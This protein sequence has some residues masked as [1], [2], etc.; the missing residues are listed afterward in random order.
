MV[1]EEQEIGMGKKNHELIPSARRLISSLR[2][3]GYDFPSAVADIVDNSIEAGAGRVSI[4]I[5]NDGDDSSVRICDDGKGMKPAEVREALR[6][7]STREY[8]QEKSLGKFGLGLKTASMSQCQHL[9]VASRSNPNQPQICAYAWDLAHIV[10]TDRWEILDVGRE[11]HTELLRE[12]LLA[13]TGTVVLWRR[14]DRILGLKHP[15]SGM[16]KKRILGMCSELEE[17]LAMVFHRYLAGEAG[18]RRVR[19]SVNGKPLRP[20]DPFVRTE[21]STV[22]LE[23]VVLKYDHDGIKGSVLMEPYVLPHQDEFSSPEAHGVAAGSLRW[24]RQQGFYIYRADRMVQSGGWSN[25][26][27][28]D[29]HTKLARVA[30]S[31]DPCLDDAFRINVAKMRV[32]LPRQLCEGIE[33]A[34]APVVK[35]AQAA[36]RRS[37]SSGRVEAPIRNVRSLAAVELVRGD[38]HVKV[39]KP[40]S[41]GAT[42]K[43]KSGHLR[44]GARLWTIQELQDELMRIATKEEQKVVLALINRLSEERELSDELLLAD[45]IPGTVAGKLDR[46]SVQ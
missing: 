18:R 16:I 12:P 23:P 30:L 34:M 40:V 33:K 26:R 46:H 24:N 42:S 6:Y 29:E 22:R 31:F 44:V 17:H 39:L 32:Q 37:S 8:D 11:E 3:M 1:Q 43:S 36:Y 21:K 10:E 7:G 35:T 15:Y 28:L 19:I 41:G 13:R 38:D 45:G 27:T 20:W 9:L 25:L 14:L 5:R 4:D 2:D